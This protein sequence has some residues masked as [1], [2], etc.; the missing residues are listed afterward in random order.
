MI[1]HSF[2]SSTVDIIVNR[3]LIANRNLK[4]KLSILKRQQHAISLAFCLIC[5]RLRRTERN[6]V[7]FNA[8]TKLCRLFDEG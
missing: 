4:A 3:K 7:A 8:V 2:V 5:F 6:N 1:L